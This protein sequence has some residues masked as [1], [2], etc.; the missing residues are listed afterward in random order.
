MV[1]DHLCV[2]EISH[3]QKL[4]RIR[5]RPLRSKS[6]Q[7]ISLTMKKALQLFVKVGETF[8]GIAECLA[9]KYGKLV[10]ND[11]I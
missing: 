8:Q 11:P 3:N 7:T 5:V 4:M 6:E 2:V 10:L 9:F 1:S